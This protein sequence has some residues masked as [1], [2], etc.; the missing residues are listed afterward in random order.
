MIDELMPEGVPINVEKDMSKN[1]GVSLKRVNHR[2][3]GK[4]LLGYARFRHDPEGDFWT[5][6]TSATSDANIEKEMVNFRTVVKLPKVAGILRGYVNTNIPDSGIFQTGLSF[7]IR[8][9]KDVKSLTVPIKNSYEDVN[10]NTD[11]SALQINKTQINK[12][13]KTFR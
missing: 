3:N 1:I 4:E 12:L 8:G 10:T 2:L 13:L 9:E 6:A 11:G 5:R 7:G